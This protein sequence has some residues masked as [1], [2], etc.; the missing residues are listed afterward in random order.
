[1]LKLVFLRMNIHLLKNYPFSIELALYLGQKSM[2][3]LGGFNG[4][5]YNTF[6]EEI[7]QIL[8]NLF[9]RIEAEGIL[10][11]SFYKAALP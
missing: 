1:M 8:S 7:I 2:D 9:Q 11:N 4:K 5:F 6:K 10:P 3:F